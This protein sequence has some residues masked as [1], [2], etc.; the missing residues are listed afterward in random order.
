[1][2]RPKSLA[3]VTFFSSLYTIYYNRR[4]LGLILY[5]KYPELLTLVAIEFDTILRRPLL[6]LIR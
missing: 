5:K 2:V 6:N 3:L 4:N 1:M